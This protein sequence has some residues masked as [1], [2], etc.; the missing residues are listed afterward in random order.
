MSAFG[1][2]ADI[3]IY[4]AVRSKTRG[5]AQRMRDHQANMERIYQDQDY[6]LTQAWRNPR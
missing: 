5:V 3:E 1:G 2:K 4:P 6:E